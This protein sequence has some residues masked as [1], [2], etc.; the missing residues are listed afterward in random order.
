MSFDKHIQDKFSGFEPEVSEEQIAAGWEKISYFLPPQEKKKRGLFFYRKSK[1]LGIAA[2]VSAISAMGFLFMKEQGNSKTLMAPEH[3]SPAPRVTDLKSTGTYHD[4]SVWYTEKN[5]SPETAYAGALAF[6]MKQGVV[7]SGANRPAK[8]LSIAHL[9][10]YRSSAAGALENTSQAKDEKPVTSHRSTQEAFSS[11]PYTM[12]DT[13][14][15][16]M[17][18]LKQASI[19]QEILSGLDPELVLYRIGRS[20]SLLPDNRKPSLEFFS[21]FSNRSSLL[22]REHSKHA[23]QAEGFSAGIAAIF[24]LKPKLYACGQFLVSYNP[25]RYLEE[26]NA[27]A[28]LSRKVSLN[29]TSSINNSMDTSVYYMPYT[30]TFELKSSTAYHLSGGVGYQLLNRGRISLDGTLLLNLTWMRFNYQISRVNSDTGVFVNTIHTPDAAS[31]YASAEKSA[32]PEPVSSHK[33]VLALG[34]NPSLSLVY[35]LNKKAGL[36]FK[37]G[38]VMQLSQNT[39]HVN[40]ASYRLKDNNWFIALGLRYRL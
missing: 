22:Q 18:L 17:L 26:T 39:L 21:G 7:P 40:N 29:T 23:Q 4:T 3:R 2:V 30:S 16:F 1:G 9:K 15:E 27:N 38:Y 8:L 19:D 36:V 11:F 32:S 31:F 34:L 28:I 12:P 10:S 13:N 37:P 35:Q 20:D 25:V 5:S 14:P 24:P 6:R 33:Q